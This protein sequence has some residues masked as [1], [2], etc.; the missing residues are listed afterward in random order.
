ML[1]YRGSSQVV[2]VPDNICARHHH[3]Y[4]LKS[5]APTN[6]DLA[7]VLQPP[8]LPCSDY[9]FLFVL[10]RAMVGHA[11]LRNMRCGNDWQNIVVRILLYGL[12]QVSAR[13]QLVPRAT[14]RKHALLVAR[15]KD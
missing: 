14:V 8:G 9:H 2:H 6:T 15:G 10:R 12:N 13:S 11:W 5:Y 1:T 7:G 3:Y 4:W